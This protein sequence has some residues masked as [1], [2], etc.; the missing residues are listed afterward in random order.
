MNQLIEHRCEYR[1]A[2]EIMIQTMDKALIEDNLA[3]TIPP[4]T[5]RE[6]AQ[7]IRELCLDM[8]GAAETLR[9]IQNGMG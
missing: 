7:N 5:A 9:E 2:L 1:K 4:A 8:L 6:Y 3:G